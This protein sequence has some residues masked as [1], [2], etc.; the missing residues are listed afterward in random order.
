[1]FEDGPQTTPLSV[2]RSVAAKPHVCD[3]CGEAI[4][5]GTTYTRHV[6]VCSDEGFQVVRHH[7]RACWDTDQPRS[8]VTLPPLDGSDIPF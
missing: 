1:M 8:K 2:R 3:I 6:W 4:G 7:Q 5:V